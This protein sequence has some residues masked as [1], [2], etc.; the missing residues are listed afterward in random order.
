MNT[1]IV[2]LLKKKYDLDNHD[3]EIAITRVNELE[4]AV[5]KIRGVEIVEDL[6]QS[7]PLKFSNE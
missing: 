1:E 2:N 3:L 6:A 5:K 4:E 7:N